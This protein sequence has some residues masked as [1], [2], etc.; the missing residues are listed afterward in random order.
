MSG[1]LDRDFAA[2]IFDMDGT[3][4]DSTP[5]VIRSW[6]TWALEYGITAE[7]LADSHGLP[8][9]AL[10]RRLIPADRAEEATRRI[11]DLELTDL[12]GVVALPGA[13]RALQVLGDRAAIATSST[14]VLADA[15]LRASGI[16][17]P[18]V[19]I[20]VDDVTHGKPDPEPFRTAAHRLGQRPEDCLVVED[21]P[22]GLAGAADAGCATLAVVTTNTPD[23]LTRADL[24]VPNLGQ[25]DW[26]LSDRGIRLTR[27]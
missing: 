15:R 12:D 24:I 23:R 5:A 27:R 11:V 10:V 4:I 21:A 18:T 1:A 20:T 3:L 9:A 16:P 7:Q 14:R 13:A 2:V 26:S 25:V 8:A 6:T 22:A 17:V 19:V